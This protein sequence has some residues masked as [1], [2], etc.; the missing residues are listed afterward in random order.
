MMQLLNISFLLTGRR[1]CHSHGQ[2]WNNARGQREEEE[3]EEEKAGE[4][5]SKGE[6][7]AFLRERRRPEGFVE[8]E[9]AQCRHLVCGSLKMMSICIAEARNQ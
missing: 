1:W 3:K 5:Q 2:R 9:A 7:V 4:G 8:G 6:S